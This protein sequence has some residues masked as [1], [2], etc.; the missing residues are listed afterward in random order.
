MA[1]LYWIIL[2]QHCLN[3]LQHSL[4]YVFR[5]FLDFLATLAFSVTLDSF[6]WLSPKCPMMVP[7]TTYNPKHPYTISFLS[8]SLFM[9]ILSYAYLSYLLTRVMK[10]I[11]LNSK[12]EQDKRH[13][14]FYQ[15][16]ATDYP[17]TLHQSHL[18]V[19][20]LDND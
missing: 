7:K 2:V 9:P 3:P 5:L 16:Q 15:D 17:R 4:C 20:V 13:L 12:K 18:I 14:I 11:F 8:F 10:T 1:V 6:S 19:I